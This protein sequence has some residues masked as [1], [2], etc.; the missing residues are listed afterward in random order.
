MPRSKDIL[1]RF[2]V[3]ALGIAIAH[4]HAKWHTGGFPLK[5]ATDDFQLIRFVTGCA[6]LPPMAPPFERLTELSGGKVKIRWGTVYQKAYRRPV[7][8]PK[9]ADSK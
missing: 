3:S 2:I 1:Q 8:L 4:K 6:E 9:S 5:D 7:R